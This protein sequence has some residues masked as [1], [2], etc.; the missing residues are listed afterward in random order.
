[1]NIHTDEASERQW[2]VPAHAATVKPFE[3]EE[4]SS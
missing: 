2:L 3:K 4:S 1:M